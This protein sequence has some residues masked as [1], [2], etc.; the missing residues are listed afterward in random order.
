MLDLTDPRWTQLHGGYHTPYDPRPA[1]AKLE[2]DQDVT[3][4]WD[5]LWQ[6]LHHQGD[7]GTVS[8]A[9][10]PHLLRVHEIRGV[11]DWNTFAL[12]GCIERARLIGGNPEVPAWLRGGYET[13][14]QDLVRLAL[15]DLARSA[16]PTLVQSALAV[17]AMARGLRRVGA[18]LLDFTDDE[19]EEMVEAYR[20]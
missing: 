7:V 2:H 13:A 11:P 16:D 18:V 6:E 15:G 9:A 1:L 20:G 17:I 8:Y 4:A 3:E 5:E 19:L 12:A 10:V 14:W